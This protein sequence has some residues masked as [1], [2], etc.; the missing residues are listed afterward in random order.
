[1]LWEIGIIIAAI[2]FAVLVYYLVDTLRA[3]KF[4]LDEVR[5]T[6]VEVKHEITTISTEVKGVVNTTNQV[7]ADVN[8]KLHSLDGLFRSVGDMGQVIH[9]AT[10]AVKQ[11]AVSFIDSVKSKQQEGQQKALKS[12]GSDKLQ[13]IAKGTAIASKLLQSYASSKASAAAPVRSGVQSKSL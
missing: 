10:S 9:E 4:S 5:L 7:A 1:M 11:S 13:W 6:L 3:L 8:T 12:G 2:A